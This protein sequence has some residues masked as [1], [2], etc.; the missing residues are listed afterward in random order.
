MQISQQQMYIGLAAAGALLSGLAFLAGRRRNN[1]EL[2]YVASG[3]EP[4][5]VKA[6]AKPL[7][8]LA[9]K[10]SV[11]AAVDTVK[12]VAAAKKK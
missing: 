4:A 2:N 6:A 10:P 9:K 12:K 8:K 7:T 11:K 3:K 5:L 1:F